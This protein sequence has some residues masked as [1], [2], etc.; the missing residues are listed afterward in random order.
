MLE[1]SLHSWRVEVG[2]S[3]R[4]VLPFFCVPFFFHL[5]LLGTACGFT[6]GCLNLI[7]YNYTV[8]CYT[9]YEYALVF[10]CHVFL[11][12]LI[13]LPSCCCCCCCSAAVRHRVPDSLL[14][15]FITFHFSVFFLFSQTRFIFNEPLGST[16]ACTASIY[17]RII[18]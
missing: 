1:V 3:I 4:G 8:R 13:V 16:V 9:T 18:L 17:L 11:L 14:L 6:I 12:L 5:F 10:T 7:D 2:R 15:W